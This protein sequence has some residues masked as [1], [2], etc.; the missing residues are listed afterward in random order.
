MQVNI[1][2]FLS[3]V[4]A[5]SSL[6]DKPLYVT[7]FFLSSVCSIVYK[8]FCPFHTSLFSNNTLMIR[9]VINC[10]NVI[11]FCYKTSKRLWY[12]VLS[13]HI[14]SKYCAFF[15]SAE[16]LVVFMVLITLTF[17]VRFVY[18]MICHDCCNA[19]ANTQAINQV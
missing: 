16:L 19:E 9:V 7:F 18:G 15:I 13:S 12:V 3:D 1:V 8:C 2:G 11:I 5:V 10:F 4:S 6:A 17:N 14:A